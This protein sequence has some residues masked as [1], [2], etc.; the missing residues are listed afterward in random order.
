MVGQGFSKVNLSQKERK[1]LTS[2]R[3]RKF[4][5]QFSMFIAEGEKVIEPLLSS[6]E[7]ELLLINESIEPPYPIFTKHIEGDKIRYAQ[8]KQMKE[9]SEM[10]SRH[11]YMAIFHKKAAPTLPNN[12]DSICVG[13][14]E[15]QNPG[16]MGTLIRL[17]DWLGIK[18]ILCSKGCVDV[19]S[20][21]VVQATAGALGNVE[22]YEDINFAKDL[23][24]R[25]DTVLST[26]LDGRNYLDFVLPSPSTIFLFGNEGNGLSP[27][28]L[29]SS[30]ISLSI[31][32]SSTTLSESLN[33]S[34]S[35]AILLSHFKQ[36]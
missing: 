18:S 11:D 16:N 21:K 33:V 34:L 3:I 6:F 5:D 30:H 14:E 13:L 36:N 25:F 26:T 8:P 12:F 2:L 27:E 22:V 24:N 7:V 28:A 35:A 23:A 10:E 4:R 17:C 20:P 9:L 32:P 19:Y 1:L 31:P 29:S 15:L